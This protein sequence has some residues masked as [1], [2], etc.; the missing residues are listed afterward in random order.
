MAS[1]GAGEE[2]GQAPAPEESPPP[3]R[4]RKVEEEEQPLF[5]P[6]IISI[7]KKTLLMLVKTVQELKDGVK[8]GQGSRE[9]SPGHMKSTSQS[10]DEEMQEDEDLN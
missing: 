9:S 8:K 3:K 5:S 10:E 6:E 1:K 7:D 4:P 2:R